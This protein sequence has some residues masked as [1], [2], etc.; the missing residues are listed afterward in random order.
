M[1]YHY[2]V[3]VFLAEKLV[4]YQGGGLRGGL[5]KIRFSYLNR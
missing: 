1:V 2:Q 4:A 5:T 3:F